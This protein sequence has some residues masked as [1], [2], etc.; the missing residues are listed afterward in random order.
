VMSSIHG[1]WSVGGLASAVLGSL[2]LPLMPASRE[3]IVLGLALLILFFWMW[4]RLAGGGG[5]PA[6][7]QTKV[8]RNS[9]WIWAIAMLAFLCFSTE[10]SV[11]DWSALY[12][13][14]ALAA[15]LGRAAW[16]YAAYSA[17]MGAGRIAGDWI[18]HHASDRTIVIAGGTAAAIGF[19]LAAASGNY[20]LAIAGFALVG[21]GLSN[22]VPIFVSAAG[23]SQQPA[24]A[25]SLV[26]T[27]GYA[28]YLASPPALGAIAGH[29]SLAAMFLV[30][31]AV[32]LFIALAWPFVLSRQPSH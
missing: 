16:G 15:P 10:G 26:V 3:A 18:R 30:V 1:L 13:G 31:G 21:I 17:C 25:V 4:R 9:G 7:S 11:R 23:R 6:R 24:A 29:A 19:C 2:L 28:G 22:I 14:G 12:L 32:A 5:A 8:G 27:M 20:V